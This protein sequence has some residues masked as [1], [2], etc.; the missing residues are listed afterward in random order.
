MMKWGKRA[1]LPGYLSSLQDAEG[2]A[3]GKK[4]C[5]EKLSVIGGLDPYETARNER[6][7]DIDL[8]PSVTSIHIVMYLLVKKKPSVGALK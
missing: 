5:L 2:N 3:E 6:L 1:F 4:R 8:W 7:D